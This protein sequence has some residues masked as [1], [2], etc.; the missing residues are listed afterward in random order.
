MFIGCICSFCLANAEPYT[1]RT[2]E[3]L[4][5]SEYITTRSIFGKSQ[6][7]LQVEFESEEPDE[8][9]RNH[10]LIELLT[11][12]LLP[13][14]VQSGKRHVSIWETIA[15]GKSGPEVGGFSLQLSA[16]AYENYDF[17]L[18]ENW[19]WEQKSG[20]SIDLS[21]V[22]VRE[23]NFNADL[24]VYMT[25]P[26]ERLVE[27]WKYYELW[28]TYENASPAEATQK[29]NEIFRYFS[30][31]STDG[32]PIESDSFLGERNA[33]A[34]RIYMVPLRPSSPLQ[35]Q[36][37]L[38]LTFGHKDYVG[39]C[40]SITTDVSESWEDLYRQLNDN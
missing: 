16:G 6:L 17:E 26:S 25:E 18:G 21:V 12:H 3:R 9:L 19:I 7:V 36:P 1:L 29:A 2:G 37:R 32:V 34:L 14:A 5:D 22:D 11:E 39:H 13:S 10:S 15:Q 4:T 8:N 40:Y 33:I 23:Q 38:K 28:A 20:P 31:C 24:G 35:S 27:E 30:G